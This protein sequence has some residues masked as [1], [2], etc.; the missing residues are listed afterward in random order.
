MKHR[1]AA[2]G[3]NGC[4]YP[5]A[6]QTDGCVAYFSMLRA[7]AP[8]LHQ[9]RVVSVA[10]GGAHCLAITAGGVLY[11][12]GSNSVGQ[13]G[14]EHPT[15]LPVAHR[16]LP[17][18]V[19]T[20]QPGAH[21]DVGVGSGG[22]GRVGGAAVGSKGGGMPTGDERVDA[23]ASA[24]AGSGPAPEEGPAGLR[25]VSI[26]A[27]LAHSVA[28]VADGRVFA[29]GSNDRGQL[30]LAN[31]PARHA[32][33]RCPRWTWGPR[34]V[35]A[36]SMAHAH[37]ATAARPRHHE[38]APP[39]VA[40]AHPVSPGAGGGSRRSSAS[41][42]LAAA[43]T[44]TT[45]ASAGHEQA[46]EV[47]A[48]SS[49]TVVL[50]RSGHVFACGDNAAGQCSGVV[51]PPGRR[52]DMKPPTPPEPVF[53]DPS[54]PQYGTPSH[55]KSSGRNTGATNGH[56][57]DVTPSGGGGGSG[58]DGDGASPVEA[59]GASA[60]SDAVRPVAHPTLPPNPTARHHRSASAS[61]TTRASERLPAAPPARHHAAECGEGAVSTVL[62][63]L[64]S[65]PSLSHF[66]RMRIACAAVTGAT[67]CRGS[68][69]VTHIACG[70]SHVSMAGFCSVHGA[71]SFTVVLHRGIGSDVA[72]G[73]NPS[74]PVHVRTDTSRGMVPCCVSC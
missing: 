11:A 1:I 71:E 55:A 19:R 8:T 23:T 25:V 46:R 7:A 22:G 42:W 34:L 65:R 44:I 26:A 54:V 4:T 31:S 67:A 48:G 13:L 33:F 74:A 29:W 45:P 43:T 73:D 35:P 39:P 49:F 27:G 63:E 51:P 2:R 17:V 20:P 28:V 58:G 21:G 30:G 37:S 38:S 24:G 64:H 16:P 41:Q 36:F 59:S 14:A 70:A 6:V 66:L 9:R 18:A 10:V 32:S 56:G 3:G 5:G 40:A 72:G 52:W 50:T 68:I 12:W 47:H 60:A 53:H 57:D 15:T 69:V 61:P 62:Q